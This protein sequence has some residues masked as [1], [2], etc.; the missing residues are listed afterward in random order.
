MTAL[1]ILEHIKLEV[2]KL[3]EF[4][5][6]IPHNRSIIDFQIGKIFGMIDFAVELEK[7]RNDMIHD[8]TKGLENMLD[9]M[10]KDLKRKNPRIKVNISG[11]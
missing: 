5:K 1:K 6:S 2:K 10:E 11:E 4:E 7:E 9:D 3:E 8:F